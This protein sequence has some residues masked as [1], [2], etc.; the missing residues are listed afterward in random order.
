MAFPC[1]QC[2]K[3]HSRVLKVAEESLGVGLCSRLLVNSS[4]TAADPGTALQL[5]TQQVRVLGQGPSRQDQGG[6]SSFYTHGWGWREDCAYRLWLW[7]ESRGG[8]SE[9]G[10]GEVGSEELRK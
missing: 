3:L 6:N 10:W 7:S 9:K 4:V 2:G 1:A 8:D 5:R